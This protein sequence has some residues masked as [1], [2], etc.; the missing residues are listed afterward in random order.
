M[1]KNRLGW[2]RISMLLVLQFLKSRTVCLTIDNL[3]VVMG[4]P[5]EWDAGQA[6]V[7]LLSR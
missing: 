7:N 3:I 2:K 1:F 5:Q 4:L 6:T